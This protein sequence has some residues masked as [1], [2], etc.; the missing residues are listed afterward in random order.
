MLTGALVAWMNLKKSLL[1]RTE[2]IQEL[3]NFYWWAGPLS[4]YGQLNG[5]D[6]IPISNLIHITMILPWDYLLWLG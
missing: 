4:H 1:K 3:T 5:F 2:L 6:I